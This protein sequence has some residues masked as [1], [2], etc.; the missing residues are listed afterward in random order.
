[1]VLIQRGAS[2]TVL[3]FQRRV[4]FLQPV[5]ARFSIP[6]NVV[7]TAAP[8]KSKALFFRFLTETELNKRRLSL[9]EVYE[10]YSPSNSDNPRTLTG[11]PSGPPI[12]DIAPGNSFLYL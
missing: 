9:N 5:L 7:G 1:M 3:L 6:G 11:G 4:E 12:F 2:D 8:C 10:I